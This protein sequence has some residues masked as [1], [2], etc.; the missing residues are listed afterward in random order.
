M[1]LQRLQ[2][3]FLQLSILL[4]IND[5]YLT[6]SCCCLGFSP[7]Q[8]R[9][10][11]RLATSTTSEPSELS[12]S[13]HL[14]DETTLLSSLEK[15]QGH[16]EQRRRRL[17]T[18][19]NPIVFDVQQV[20]NAPVMF[21]LRN[22]VSQEERNGLI[23]RAQCSPQDLT[24]YSSDNRRNRS[25]VSWLSNDDPVSTSLANSIMK[26]ILD[27]DDH[28]NQ[29]NITIGSNDDMFVTEELQI[30][31][32]NPNGEFK[33]HH[34]EGGRIVTVLYYLNGIA[35][36]W[37]PLATTAYNPSTIDTNENHQEEPRPSPSRRNDSLPPTN[38]EDAIQRVQKLIPGIDGILTVG[39]SSHH[40]CCD[41]A[42]YESDSDLS[43]NEDVNNGSSSNNN[44][45]IVPIQPGDALVFSNF[46]N[47]AST[48]NTMNNEIDWNAIHAGL[49]AIEE[50]WIATHWF[51]EKEN[52][53]QLPF[54]LGL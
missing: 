3:L 24:D 26:W 1:L 18:F 22:F 21:R 20:S 44:N 2:L 40:Y 10:H 7:Q 17:D 39:N 46:I 49:P 5:Y 30:V 38:E 42:Q 25:L 14:D 33:L 32:Y 34:D 15:R 28:K 53:L 52:Y 35:G 51:H 4:L 43:H 19:G 13:A 41:D 11:P 54:L 27:D 45:A 36:T 23:H 6:S 8:D 37:F 50:K 12:L 29:K 48:Q 47:S 9:Y 16:H 31:K